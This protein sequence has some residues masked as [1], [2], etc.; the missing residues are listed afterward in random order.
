MELFSSPFSPEAVDFLAGLDMPAYKIASFELVD[1][2]LIRR[3]ARQ[4]RPLVMSTGMA[5]LG[6][7]EEAVDA[8]RGEGC[9]ELILLKCTSSYPAPPEEMNL[10]TMAHMAAAFDLPVG[11]SDHTTGIAVPV[12]AVALGA[13][14][15]EKHF[16]MSRADGG[17]ESGFALEPAEFKAM[18]DAV[19]VA[20]R[21]LGAVH[22]GLTE[23]E[24]ASR[25]YRRSLF[26]VEDVRA[27]EVL[28]PSAVRS[29]RPA[30]GLH[31]RY[32][33]EVVGRRARRDLA[34]GTPLS[35]Q[36]LD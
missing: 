17:P 33:D 20:E 25:I 11:L 4:G 16:I 23:K 3:A 5:T 12:A 13:V 24:R 27:G 36:D 30:H 35:W 6:E 14:M 26:V 29:I 2:P 31:P 9:E 34:A 32:L 1:L 21:A 7:V 8:A 15:V 19:R 28:S 18:V 10:R 22:Y